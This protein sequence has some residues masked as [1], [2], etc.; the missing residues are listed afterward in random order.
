M[1][2]RA[3]LG[4]ICISLA[5]ASPGAAQAPLSAIDWLS[6]SVSEP[7]RLGAP[8]EAETTSRATPGVIETRP[9]DQPR[10]DALGIISAAQAG[11][12]AD[13]WR[14]ARTDEVQIA[15]AQA[16]R[17]LPPEM[18]RLI[19]RLLTVQADPPTETGDDGAVFLARVDLLLELGALPQARDLL[20]S[21]GADDPDQFRRYFD[22]SLLLGDDQRACAA[23]QARPQIA[24]TYP[25]R[26]FC[27][28]RSGDWPA[29]AVTLETAEALGILT[30]AEDQLLARFLDDTITPTEPAP[31]PVTPLIFRL[32]AAVGDPVPTMTLPLAFAHADLHATSGWKA[33]L[34][35]AERLVRA[36]ALS[37]QVLRMLYL[38]R[39]A[40]ASGGVWERV[41]SLQAFESALA[42]DAPEAIAAT[43]PRALDEM[44]AAGL[45]P[46]FA[47]LY[48]AR[49][50]AR[51]LP[52]ELADLAFR[53]GLA[54][55]EYEAVALSRLEGGAQDAFLV[56]LARGLPR[57]LA[58]GSTDALRRALAE[59]FQASAPTPE[60]RRLLA[61]KGAGLAILRGI[62]LFTEGARG[63]PDRLGE[64]LA[65][66]RSLGLEQT[67]R[68]AALDLLLG[69][70]QG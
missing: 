48:G 22:A 16:P 2:A 17:D 50:A 21:A 10:R 34:D 69:D 46:A 25:A 32:L 3:L 67:A 13:L 19:Q 56:A 40:A 8:R 11:L 14:G 20:E 52:P 39:R 55:P 6:D 5:V 15:L 29:A 51:A 30:P 44:R 65:L 28:A 24:P 9:L 49:L 36:G 47:E 37:P 35:A 27:L 68:R 31:S 60:L 18:R 26:I 57:D 41:A 1:A 38:E 66:F 58:A 4:A 42:G 63:D 61:E 43:L 53:I 62:T 64:A 70:G 54:S 7:A 12:P 59:G 33:R 23:L 45:G